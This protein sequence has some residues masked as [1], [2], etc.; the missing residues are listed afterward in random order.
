MNEGGMGIWVGGT[1]RTEM[2]GVGLKVFFFFFGGGDPYQNPGKFRML[3]VLLNFLTTNQQTHVLVPRLC[4]TPLS[5]LTSNVTGI[6]SKKGCKR[7]CKRG[8]AVRI[9]GQR[10]KG[11]KGSWQRKTPWFNTSRFC[12]IITV[13]KLNI[14]SYFFIKYS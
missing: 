3:S 10:Q 11:Q 8:P 14:I 6:C 13:C 1:Y 12:D 2:F 7:G 4:S 9:K 5:F